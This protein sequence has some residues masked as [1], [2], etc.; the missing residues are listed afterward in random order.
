MKPLLIVHAQKHAGQPASYA[1]FMD[2][3]VSK[4]F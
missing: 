3:Q 1:N 4:V 2:T